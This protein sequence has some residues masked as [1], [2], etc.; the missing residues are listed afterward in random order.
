MICCCILAGT[1]A[2]K[3]CFNNNNSYSWNKTI[4]T[5]IPIEEELSK[6]DY[7]EIL[8][9]IINKEKREVL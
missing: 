9:Y 5:T 8:K 4:T 7:K 3:H 2:C 1:E 6:E